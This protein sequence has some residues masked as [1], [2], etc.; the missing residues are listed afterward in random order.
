M[1]C[2]ATHSFWS[3]L[4]SGLWCRTLHTRHN[5]GVL[6]SFMATSDEKRQ[7]HRF[8]FLLRVEYP[9]G[10]EYFTEW[11]ENLSAGGLFVRTERCFRRGETIKL[12]LS[13]PGL[14]EPVEI[15][16]RVAWVRAV[17]PVQAGGI[18][19]EV[20]NETGRRR[21]VDL[22]LR[23]ADPDSLAV[24]NLFRVLIV[25]DNPRVIRSYERVL[26]HATRL[27]GGRVELLFAVNGHEAVNVLAQEKANLVITDIYM[28]ILDGF[29]LVETLRKNPKTIN[30]PIIMISGGRAD[31]RQRAEELG[32]SAF[33]HKP[34]QFGQLLETIVFLAASPEPDGSSDDS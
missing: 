33:L 32:V 31:E 11:T 19:V 8:P 13:F 21:L 9:G 15:E 14:L 27:A 29:G 12:A 22:A 1:S 18:G 25:E 28:P 30:I 6:K 34:V 4:I 7:N 10:Q 26:K 5:T 20:T 2:I 23:A 3:M 24:A 17:G 16:G